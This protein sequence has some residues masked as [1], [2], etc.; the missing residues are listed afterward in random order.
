MSYRLADHRCATC[1]LHN[2]A[3]LLTIRIIAIHASGKVHLP[4]ISSKKGPIA[5]S[6][7]DCDATSPLSSSAFDS[8]CQSIPK[9]VR[10]VLACD[11]TDPKGN[12]S[13]QSLDQSC[14]ITDDYLD[15]G[16]SPLDTVDSNSKTSSA[17]DVS[18]LSRLSTSGDL[19]ETKSNTTTASLSTEPAILCSAQCSE[20]DEWHSHAPDFS[21]VPA[22]ADDGES[23]RDQDVKVCG[24]TF[25][26]LV[27]RLLADPMSKSDSR[28]PA[29][30]LCL[31]R[32]FAAPS[33]LLLAIMQRFEDAAVANTP[34]LIRMTVQLRYLARLQDWIADFPGDFAH[35]TSRRIATSF[36]QG[37]ANQKVFAVAHQEINARLEMVCEDDDTEWACSDRNRS[38]A[39][40]M[41]SFLT[42]SSLQSATSTMTADSST[43]D[44]VEQPTLKAAGHHIARMKTTALADA[45]SENTSPHSTASLHVCPQ[46]AEDVNSQAYS[47][48]P[49]PRIVLNKVRWHQIMEIS[50][51]SIAR[52]LT[53]IDWILYSSIRSRDL[54]R[55]ISLTGD[56]R[57]SCKGLEHVNQMID[58]FNHTAF[59]VANWILL[60]DKPKHRAKALEKFMGVAWKLRHLNNYNSLGAVIAGINGTAVHRL[61]QT[62]ELVSSD[63]QKQFMR[64]EILMG[65]QKSYSAYRLAWENT[66]S[67]R[68]PF[69]P[70]HRKDLVIAEEANQTFVASSIGDIIN[71]RKFEVMGQA[72]VEIRKSQQLQYQPIKP[73][74]DLQ[75]LLL[76]GIFSKE[77]D[78]SAFRDPL[79]TTFYTIRRA[80]TLTS[81]RSCM[82][83][84]YK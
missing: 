24:V 80:I 43:Q 83:V 75:R 31:Y 34:G 11:I 5:Q 49:V 61:S 70:L 38:R 59:W 57:L 74:E 44:N 23:S 82:S 42:V 10:Y 8:A 56:E 53:R 77:D 45:S 81:T 67:A 50:E 35:P 69:L 71:W 52:E 37:F 60:R 7:S 19:E 26:D 76:D 47:L 14:A 12:A 64:L 1:F 30:F 17:A 2:V 41:E 66:S 4:G 40:T 15:D 27:D 32:K 21:N 6:T 78:V 55:H 13:S 58:Q 20:S 25:E 28:F 72:I 18:D 3:S 48:L 39:S 63:L 68:I 73:H 36:V 79:S 22:D 16:Y 29:I 65:T 46:P 51:E 9:P 62:W 84:A 54:I 33:E